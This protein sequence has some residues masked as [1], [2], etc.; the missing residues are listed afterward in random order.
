MILDL[1]F[2]RLEPTS[3]LSQLLAA[4]TTDRLVKVFDTTKGYCTHSLQG[5]RGVVLCVRF[6]PVPA[7]MQLVSSSDDRTLRVWDLTLSVCV[8]TLSAHQATVASFVF[9]NDGGTLISCGRDSKIYF[10][11]VSKETNQPLYRPTRKSLSD[12]RTSTARTRSSRLSP[13]LTSSSS[14]MRPPSP[15]KPK[16]LSPTTS[17]SSRLRILPRS[18]STRPTSSLAEARASCASST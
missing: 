10:W 2:M 5:H 13:I 4:G 3:A 7:K 14:L 6:H 12:S 8:A 15:G 17:P 18:T 16:N 11:N 9:T 1:S